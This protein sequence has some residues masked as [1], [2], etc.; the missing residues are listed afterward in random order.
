MLISRLIL[1]GLTFLMV[2]GLLLVTASYLETSRPRLYRNI[3]GGSADTD[4]DGNRMHQLRSQVTNT[5]ADE[6]TATDTPP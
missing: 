6:N 2:G 3:V 1:G 4:G 5:D